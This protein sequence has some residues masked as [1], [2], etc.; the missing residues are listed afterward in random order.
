MMK[1]PSRDQLATV[2]GLSSRGDSRPGPLCAGGCLAV[3][4]LIQVGRSTERFRKEGRADARHALLRRCA[5]RIT[6]RC[7]ARR[8]PGRITRAF[9]PGG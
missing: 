6:R 4:R 7:A 8:K 3:A 1:V 5:A 2:P 9:P